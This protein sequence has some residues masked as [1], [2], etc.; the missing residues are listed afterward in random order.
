VETA[1]S[2]SSGSEENDDVS[3]LS[4]ATPKFRFT[5]DWKGARKYEGWNGAGVEFYNEL[6]SLVEQQR[7][8][9]GCTFECDLLATLATRPKKGRM[10]NGERPPNARNHV[11]ALMEF[12]GV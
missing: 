11:S 9:P 3:T 10:K 4:G 12:V 5:G 8:H 6:L 7:D 2:T 1:A